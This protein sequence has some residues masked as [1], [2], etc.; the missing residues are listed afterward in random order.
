MVEKKDGR[1][2]LKRSYYAVCIL[3]HSML[4]VRFNLPMICG[5]KDWEFDSGNGSVSGGY[6]TESSDTM[7]RY[8]L[9]SSK[10]VQLFKLK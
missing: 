10:D 4:P 5:P 8:R 1:Y 9:M 2:V 6:L 3:D 7:Y